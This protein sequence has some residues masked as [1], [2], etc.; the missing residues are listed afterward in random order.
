MGNGAFALSQWLVVICLARLGSPTMVGQ[1]T[2]GLAI[3]TPIVLLGSL[4]LRNVLVTDIASSCHFPTYLRLRAGCMAAAFAVIVV[5]AVSVGAD[6]T[7]VIVL[8]GVAK[9]VD[10]VA[11]IYYGLF[12]RRGEMRLIGICMTSN[13]A[14]TVLLVAAILAA[15]G[16]L[17]WAVA[18]SVAASALAATMCLLLGARSGRAGGPSAATSGPADPTSAPLRAVAGAPGLIVLAAPAGLAS[19]LTALAVSI[20]RYAVEGTLGTAELGIFAALGVIVAAASTVTGALAQ[21][22]LPAMTRMWASGHPGRLRSVTW[23]GVLAAMA[24]AAVGVPLAVIF[25][26]DLMRLTYGPV[27]AA[28]AG[29]LS[30]LT[31]AVALQTAI[32]VLDAALLA[33][34]RF[35]TELVAAV[36][37]VSVAAA[38]ATVLVPAYGLIGA[39]W[40]VAVPA[41]VQLLHKCVLV[42]LAL[43]RGRFAPAAPV[44]SQRT[45]R[46]TATAA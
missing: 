33:M 17:V 38:V 28:H 1:Y 15:T 10:G 6:A 3:G 39:A 9:A 36:V 7:A 41:T 21:V 45:E 31:L 34:R 40:A 44:Q 32:F 19:C 35:G 2:L 29:I 11:D 43:R 20:P 23:R 30:I 42:R 24:G 16:D 25:G 14:L 26:A 13:A 5:M 22:L 18:G 46:I 12:Q 27:Y 8:V 4:A 37:T